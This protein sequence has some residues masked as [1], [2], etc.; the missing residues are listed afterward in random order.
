MIF[1]DDSRGH[2]LVAT[3]RRQL[4]DALLD[5]LPEEPS[6]GQLTMIAAGCLD[7]LETDIVIDETS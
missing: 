1:L 2:W 7:C 5:H 4:L 6:L 3:D